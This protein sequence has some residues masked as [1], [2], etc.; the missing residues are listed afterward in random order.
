MPAIDLD[1]IKEKLTID[2]EKMKAFIQLMVDF[3]VILLMIIIL[4][5][6]G[7]GIW[8]AVKKTHAD[9]D[10]PLSKRFEKI[11]GY[12]TIAF[13]CAALITVFAIYIHHLRNR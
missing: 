11:L 8:M 3:R 7:G 12:I 4:L 13:C 10:N 9:V 2:P 6:M 5:V 1:A